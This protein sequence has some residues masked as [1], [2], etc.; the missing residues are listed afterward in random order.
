VVTFGGVAYFSSAGNQAELTYV[1]NFAGGGPQLGLADVHLYAFN[2]PAMLVSVAPGA[3][4][5]STLHWNNPYGSSADDYDLYIF[6]AALQ[7]VLAVSNDIQNGFG[8]PVEIANYKNDDNDVVFINIVV[9]RAAGSPYVDLHLVN[10]GNGITQHEYILPVGGIYGHSCAP[11]AVAVGAIPSSAFSSGSYAAQS[12]STFGP[13]QMQFPAPAMRNK[14]EIAG[15]DGVSITGAG[16]FGQQIPSGSGNYYF[17]GTSAAA[18]HAAAVAALL[19]ESDPTLT[20]AQITQIMT[21]TAVDL[22][23]TGWDFNIG[24]GRLDAYN[25]LA[26]RGRAYFSGPR[27]P[28]DS[29]HPLAI[30]T[31]SITDVNTVNSV[32]VSLVCAHTFVGDLIVE[33]EAPGAP[34]VMLMQHPGPPPMGDDGNNPNIVLSDNAPISIDNINFGATQDIFGY[35]HPSPGNLSTLGG[36]QLN[37]DWILKVTDVDPGFNNGMLYHWGLSF[38]LATG[39]EDPVSGEV[40]ARFALHQN[41]PNPFNPTTIIRYELPEQSRVRLEVFNILGE[42]IAALV[43]EVQDRGT[44]SVV[45]PGAGLAS[46]VY[47]YRLTAGNHIESRMMML[48]R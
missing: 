15:I 30:D 21:T 31:I 10:F 36:V 35:Y 38:A 27:L 24:E 5:L 48:V 18:P 4:I 41:Y 14:P 6:D 17:F 28:L 47:L 39:I 44:R 7:N 29:G 1:E 42:E 11:N 32:M 33:L 9:N 22:G 3:E 23:V 37:G 8:N 40:P 45:F 25:A 12:Y 26:P 43:D 19:L 2:D 34:P 16:G 46:G 13:R 20:P